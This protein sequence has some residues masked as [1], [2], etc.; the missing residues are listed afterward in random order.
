[1]AVYEN[2]TMDVRV[3]G[4]IER[5]RYSINADAPFSN[6]YMERMQTKYQPELRD[7]EECF[8]TIADD[9]PTIVACRCPDTDPLQYSSDEERYVQRA[10][11]PEM[12]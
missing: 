1:M 10:L 2:G 7:G 12:F 6:R 4:N 11:N 8:F 9:I 5:R 3:D